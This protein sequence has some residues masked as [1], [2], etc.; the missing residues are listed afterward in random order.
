MLLQSMFIFH[1]Y[2]FHFKILP[3]TPNKEILC[4]INFDICYFAAQIWN[5]HNFL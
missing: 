5:C 4:R 2:F 3:V 1:N